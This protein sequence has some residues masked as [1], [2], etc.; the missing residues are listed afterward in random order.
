MMAQTANLG[1]GM[2]ENPETKDWLD[3]SSHDLCQL[4]QL[5]PQLSGQ[6]T[7]LWRSPR[8]F[9]AALLLQVDAQVYF[10]KRSSRLFRRVQDLQQEHQLIRY[11]DAQGIAVPQILHAHDGATAVE[12]GEWSYEVHEKAH[13]VDPYANQISWKPF[14]YAEHAAKAGKKL[15]ELHLAAKYYPV[16]Q[17]RGAKQLISN[18]DL[19]ESENIHLAILQRIQNSPALSA[20][21]AD[22]VL[23][24]VWLNQLATVH[25]KIKRTIQQA[26]KIWTHNDF[27][28]S[29]LLWSDSSD[30]AEISMVIDFGLAD[31]CSA[32]Y[33]LAVAIE[34]NFI[35]WLA[36]E[37]GPDLYIDEAGLAAFVQAYIAQA[38]FSSAL[39]M[40]PE[41]IKIVHSDFALS[42]LE[43]FVGITQNFKHADAAY[44]D[45]M[46]AHTAWFFQPQGQQFCQKLAQLIQPYRMLEP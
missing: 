32:I 21:F 34:R 44:Y 39:E 17:G 33:D 12:L 43:Y 24:S 15:A 13:G 26:P 16:T 7:I 9:S 45:W 18:Q 35:D 36:L 2:G 27:H 31:R 40:L 4:Q 41:L 30:A 23:D 25:E 37:Q 20:Y 1:H 42:E 5:Y 38:G 22:K 6:Q 19:L 46:I 29:N 3:I 11:L 10:V 28:A 14:F 8:P